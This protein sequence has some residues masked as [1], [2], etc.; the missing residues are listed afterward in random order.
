MLCE[1]A[2]SN[3]LVLRS[4]LA[5]KVADIC[6]GW[7]TI[8]SEL[9]FERDAS[10]EMICTIGGFDMEVLMLWKVVGR[11]RLRRASMKDGLV[12]V[13]VVFVVDDTFFDFVGAGITTAG[14]VDNGDFETIVVVTMR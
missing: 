7:N 2:F 1:N 8:V 10:F 4:T 11:K 14:D 6:G 9:R 3:S 12:V 13:V 5:A